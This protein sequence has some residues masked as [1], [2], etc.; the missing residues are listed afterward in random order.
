MDGPGF[1]S[2]IAIDAPPAVGLIRCTPATP[3]LTASIALQVLRTAA[4]PRIVDFELLWGGNVHGEPAFA[5]A[6]EFQPAA[7]QLSLGF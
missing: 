1:E 2:D 5:A 3:R 6:S 7:P 4:L